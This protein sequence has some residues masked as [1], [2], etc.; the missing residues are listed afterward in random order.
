[1]SIDES[2]SDAARKLIARSWADPEFKK[3]LLKD[4]KKHLGDAGLLEPNILSNPLTKVAV[5]EGAKRPPWAE[6][7]PHLWL[8][9]K[10]VLGNT[11]TEEMLGDAVESLL[12]ACSA[13]PHSPMTT[14]C[15]DIT[16]APRI[17]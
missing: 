12:R 7:F 2:L 3:Q 11:V 9:P 14:C 10:P 5:Y 4:P 8:P 15:C 13:V 16:V 1:M 6:Q 17:F